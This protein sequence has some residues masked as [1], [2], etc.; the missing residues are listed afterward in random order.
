VNSR[1]PCYVSTLGFDRL[2]PCEE[3]SELGVDRFDRWEN[4]P[5]RLCRCL[6]SEGNKC[7]RDLLVALQYPLI[8]PMTKRK[9]YAIIR[10]L[11][12]LCFASQERDTDAR[13]VAHV[14]HCMRPLL[15]PY[16]DVQTIFVSAIKKFVKELA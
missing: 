15:K 6:L 3:L 4:L 9:T 11:T 8:T 16:R 12:K 14:R 5:D 2:F 7:C 13:I 1:F 10:Q